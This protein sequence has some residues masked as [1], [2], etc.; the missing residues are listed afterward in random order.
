M[1]LGPSQI[2]E[3]AML[4]TYEKQLNPQIELKDVYVYLLSN[5]DEL[6]QK[7]QFEEL[8]EE[9]FQSYEK[10]AVASS[11]E[12]KSVAP[13]NNF[14]KVNAIDEDDEVDV[15]AYFIQLVEG[16]KAHQTEIDGLID[17]H[18]TGHWSVGRLES[19]N[20]QIL[21]IAVYE[22]LYV[23]KETVPNVVAVSEALELSKLYSDD[24]SRKFINGVLSHVLTEI[25]TK[26]DQD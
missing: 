14:S 3:L 23:A 6:H 25:E 20:L 4:A 1:V 8:T 2:R 7:I 19:V 16:V 15:P 12:N 10:Y 22:M 9:D 13:K 24:R 17:K 26:V 21:R 18:I 11:D 5:I